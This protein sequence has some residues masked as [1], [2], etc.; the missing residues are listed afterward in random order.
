MFQM[1]SDNCSFLLTVNQHVSFPVYQ[2]VQFCFSVASST[3]PTDLASLFECP[4]CFDYAL[5]P[6]MQCQSGHIVCSACRPKLQFCPTC[7]GTLGTLSSFYHSL[8]VFFNRSF[9]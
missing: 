1:L 9:V 8:L 6:I 7:R 2:T 3:N 4:V 5:P